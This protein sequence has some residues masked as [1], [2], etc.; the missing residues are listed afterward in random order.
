MT[1]PE[2][3]N[4]VMRTASGAH[5]L[6]L[7]VARTALARFCGLMLTRALGPTQ[8]LLIPG[9]TSVHSCFMRCPI[10][11]VYLDR[12]GRA[13]KCVSR[14]QPWRASFGMDTLKQGHAR[15]FHTLE[16]AAGAIDAFNIRPGDH[17]ELPPVATRR[18]APQ[19]PSGASAQRGS[20]MI[21]FAVIAPIIT[22]IGLAVLQYGMLFFARNQVNH[23]SFMAAREGAAANADMAAIHA[24]YVHALVP[25][26]GGGQSPSELAASLAKADADLGADGTGNV[27]IEM[28]NPT[29]ESF[30]D[31][32]DPALQTALKTGSKRVIPNALLA[33][34][35]ANNQNVGAASGQ[36][37]Q[38]ANLI[39]LRITQGYLPK[40][41]LVNKIYTAYLRWLDP[42]TD[43][44]H[45]KL[46][47]DGR[48]PVVTH[49]LVHMQSDAIEP[50]G[51]ISSPGLGND[52]T[53][54]KPPAQP[55]IPPKP[56]PDCT[57]LGCD[58]PAPIPPPT[59]PC[60]PFSD[61]DHCMPKVCD[62][63]ADV[64]CIPKF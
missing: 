24:A 46:V 50:A 63:T 39:K 12:T 34:K 26:Y 5:R 16:L 41:P 57:I 7:R 2:T 22:L 55:Q 40:V 1:S 33:V 51:P 47:N 56:A 9:C 58:T 13:S 61:P 52:G 42:Q 3:N 11:V 17:L 54:V 30:A 6:D 8:G 59:P 18:R 25:M 43:A 36:T 14:L 49:V 28:L 62:P 21:E 20:A 32:N 29:K 64:C 48:I 60:N 4:C 35:A 27:R 10:D 53:P 38:D 45:S 19:T 44:F 15:P 37:I 23:A 31:W